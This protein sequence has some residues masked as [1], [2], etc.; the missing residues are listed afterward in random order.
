MNFM[1]DI[2]G[3]KTFARLWDNWENEFFWRPY[4]MAS[5]NDQTDSRQREL[6]VEGIL[7][8]PVR[9][10]QYISTKSYLDRIYEQMLISLSS[11]LP[12]DR[13]GNIFEAL[14]LINKLR[15]REGSFQFFLNG[16]IVTDP[17]K[18]PREQDDNEF[19]VIELSISEEG[20]AECWVY[21]CSIS[22]AYEN[23]NKEQLT[24][25]VDYLRRT[26]PEMTTETRYVIPTNKQTN[27]WSP[28]MQHTGRNYNP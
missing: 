5:T 23:N 21:A 9:L 24:K 28:K 22:D 17:Q 12:N 11:D 27:N 4:V 10:L 18:P 8:L 19:D 26:Y 3:I 14:W 16:M 13:K 20:N 15:Q 2:R 1:R 7:G 25:L 6:F